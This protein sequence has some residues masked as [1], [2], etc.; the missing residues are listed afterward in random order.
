MRVLLAALAVLA[1]AGTALAIDRVGVRVRGGQGEFFDTA[2]GERFWPRGVNYVDMRPGVRGYEDRPLATDNFDPRRISEAFARLRAHGYNTVRVFFDNCSEGPACLLT[3]DGRGLNP[4]YM[5]NMAAFTR[6]A[7]AHDMHVLFTSNDIPG[8]RYDE[9]ANRDAGA[10]AAGYRNAHFMT[11]GGV[12]AFRLY[13]RDLM[14]ALAARDVAWEAVLGW[15]I[16]N[17]EWI[18]KDQP[19]WSLTS[20]TFV[21][22]TGK[23]Y[24][25]SDPEQ[26]RAALADNLILISRVV[27]DEVRAVDPQAL[28]TMG[29]FAPQFPNETSIGGGWYVDTEPLL[30]GA[31]LDFFDFHAYVDTDLTVRQQAENFGMLVH[32]QKAVIMGEVG[33]TSETIARPQAALR[34]EQ[35][36]MAESCTVGFD[37]WLHWGYY[38]FPA[39]LDLQTTHTLTGHDGMLLAGLSPRERPDACSRDSY[40]PFANAARGATA[41]AS[42]SLPGHPPAHALDGRETTWESGTDAPGWIDIVL[43]A[44]ARLGRVTLWLA[45]YPEGETRHRVVARLADGTR[46][47]VG[48]RTART[49]EA[50]RLSFALPGGVPDVVGIRAEVVRSPSWVS[51]HDVELLRDGGTGPACLLTAAATV[52]MRG[53]AS[54]EN[55]PVGQ[56]PAGIAALGTAREPGADG[57]DWYRTALGSFVRE[58]VVSASAGCSVL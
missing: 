37:G 17:E 30:A 34:A 58:D 18:F 13:W 4:A 51:F 27:R 55:A 38:P 57:Y 1:L 10:M 31:P 5:D 56:L 47:L 21:N 48:D 16:L 11:A 20:G 52:N 8:G 41:T 22:G 45:Q 32:P 35:E 36:W 19:P 15:S 23:S 40:E 7:A 9:R 44:P 6:L 2:T 43:E 46:L 24:D 25:L 14:A 53:D 3:P 12:E 26:K 49:R 42:R 54:T 33:S 50:E 39:P 28:V 29:F